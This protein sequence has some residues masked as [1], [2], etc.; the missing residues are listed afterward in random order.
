VNTLHI[1]TLYN[2][3]KTKLR[4]AP[5]ALV[6]SSVSSRADRQ[7]RQ[8]LNAWARHVEL[9]KSCRVK[10]WWAKWNFGICVYL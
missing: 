7:A 10:T 8:S 6:V 2:L 3:N 5:V 1:I 4:A 9:V